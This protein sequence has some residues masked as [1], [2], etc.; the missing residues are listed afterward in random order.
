MSPAART[1][2]ESLIRHA[3]GML[4]ACEKYLQD[5]D[6]RAQIKVTIEK[7]KERAAANG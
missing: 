7:A 3:R 6:P 4:T 1:L 5:T 2:F